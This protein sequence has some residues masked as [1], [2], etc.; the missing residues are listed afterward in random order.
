MSGVS[1]SLTFG[2]TCFGLSLGVLAASKFPFSCAMAARKN[3]LKLRNQRSTFLYMSDLIKD[4]PQNLVEDL[5]G[6]G[7]IF[8]AIPT[9]AEQRA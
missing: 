6:L 2:M 5:T 4:S 9:V 7:V 1:H 3:F 8:C